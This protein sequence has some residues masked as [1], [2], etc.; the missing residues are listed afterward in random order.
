M[1]PADS[2]THDFLGWPL[3]VNQS[4]QADPGEIGSIENFIVLFTA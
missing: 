4:K 3:E 2:K 1:H